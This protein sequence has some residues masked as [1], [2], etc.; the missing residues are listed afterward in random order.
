MNLQTWSS[1]LAKAV[2]VKTAI[3][4]STTYTTAERLVNGAQ[5]PPRNSFAE[6]DVPMRVIHADM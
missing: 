3:A 1:L 5:P 2:V 6:K 4:L